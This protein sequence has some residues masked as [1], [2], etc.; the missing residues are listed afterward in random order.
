V[1]YVVV[2]P[3]ETLA[4]SD[5]SAVDSTSPG[6]S[7]LTA[8]V[9]DSFMT[10]PLSGA[11]VT[12]TPTAGGT[13]VSATTTAQGL[14]TF[15]NI[16]GNTNYNL[17]VTAMGYG[18]YTITHDY[19]ATGEPYESTIL[20]TG[21]SQTFDESGAAAPQGQQDHGATP[22]TYASDT[23]IP[24]VVRIRHIDR[25]PF[26]DP[27]SR[28]CMPKPGASVSSIAWWPWNF[29]VRNVEAAEIGSWPQVPWKA[30]AEAASTYAWYHRINPKQPGQYDLGDS[31]NSQCFWPGYPGKHPLAKWRDWIV[32]VIGNRIADA[33]G[34]IVETQYLAGG[35]TS[36]SD[37]NVPA[38]IFSQIGSLHCNY[39]D[40]R[41]IDNF[42]YQSS[43]GGWP[44]ATVRAGVAPKIPS[45]DF[46]SYPGSTVGVTLVFPSV[47]LR[48]GQRS[49]VG[50][51]YRIVASS[52]NGQTW[53]PIAPDIRWTGGT[54]RGVPTSFR[55]A[56]SQCLKYRVRA[57][58]PVG[59]SDWARFNNGNC[60][61]PG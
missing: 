1:D 15:V 50:W 4:P 44:G 21:A 59:W 57:R 47:V 31:T 27:Q 61:T 17:T 36:C 8:V 56:T 53:F 33:S 20:M 45:T 11:T 34:H 58:N 54:V 5:F 7:A 29:Y 22:T 12:L 25:Y 41:D 18:S 60:I 26:S 19:Y 51:R 43:G 38:H 23:M 10:T 14:V 49:Y 32:P 24:P 52:N 39:A 42:Y 3:D 35:G 48:S 46:G 2:E 28:G 30:N 6:S 37:P 13:P 55:Y 9:L 40:W 16:P